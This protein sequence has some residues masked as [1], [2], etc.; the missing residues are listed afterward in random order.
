MALVTAKPSWQPAGG[1]LLRGSAGDAASTAGGTL[2]RCSRF[3]LIAFPVGCE[4][5]RTFLCHRSLLPTATRLSSPVKSRST[6]TAGTLL[7]LS[8][9]PT[10]AAASE[11]EPT[12]TSQNQPDRCQNL[13]TEVEHPPLHTTGG[14]CV[15]PQRG[16]HCIPSAIVTTFLQ[17]SSLFQGA[18]HISTS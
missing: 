8:F 1:R 3:V 10:C 9:S 14:N 7:P 12:G 13:R 17:L 6:R 5:E 4:G 15:E 18:V 2:A 16:L 11:A